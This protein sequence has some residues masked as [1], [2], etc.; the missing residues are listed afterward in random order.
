MNTLVST[1]SAW[2]RIG[3]AVSGVATEALALEIADH[4]ARGFG[5]ELEVL[6]S[7]PDLAA[8][9]PWIAEGYIT[10][11]QLNATEMI[12]AQAAVQENAARAAF[13]AL[14]QPQKSFHALKATQWLD[15]GYRAR[16]CDLMVFDDM[17]ARGLG[18]LAE[19]FEQVLMEERTPVFVARQPLTE[20]SNVLVAWDGKTSSSQATRLALP[21]LK[22]AKRVVI[23]SVETVDGPDIERLADYLDV[24]GIVAETRLLK[25]SHDIARTLIE[26]AHD[27][28]AD[29][30]VSGAF[31][32]SRLR[33]F[34][35]GG[36]TRDLLAAPD[37]NL[38]LAH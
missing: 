28:E 10:S 19:G 5:A 38:F 2:G 13:G 27:I 12:Q 14:K 1:K 21:L 7:A 11:I 3:L 30:L 37:L 24:H 26:A 8:L 15:L 34:V 23:A 25:A 36:T 35:F 18:L 22:T 29:L 31:G 4:L 9:T 6:F 20:T 32:H 17:T 16:L 33:E